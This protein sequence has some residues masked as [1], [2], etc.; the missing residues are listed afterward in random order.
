MDDLTQKFDNLSITPATTIIVTLSYII[1]ELFR[2]VSPKCQLLAEPVPNQVNYAQQGN[3][4]SKTNNHGWRNHPNLWYKNNNH[5]FD[6]SL[7]PPIVPP[8]FHGQKGTL[9][10]PNKSNFELMENFI[11]T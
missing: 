7:E 6:A 3:P 5:M 1:S 11:M 9:A 4:Y 8:E 2:H 10:T